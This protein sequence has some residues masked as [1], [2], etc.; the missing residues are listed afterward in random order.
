MRLATALKGRSSASALP[1]RTR[2]PVWPIATPARISP[3]TTGTVSRL[4]PETIGPTRLHA[5]ISA[6]IPKLTP[7]PAEEI[8]Q[9][10]GTT[11]LRDDQQAQ[12]MF[13]G[14]IATRDALAECIEEARSN[15]TS[16]PLY[17]ELFDPTEALDAKLTAFYEMAGSFRSSSER[18]PTKA[19]NAFR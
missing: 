18:S 4:T 10:D 13:G 2:R 16:A 3:T 9:R 1:L 12:T 8:W 14:I 19:T 5:T 7:R 17:P 11:I 15:P 6:R